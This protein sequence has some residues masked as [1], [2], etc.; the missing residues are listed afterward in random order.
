MFSLAMHG[1]LFDAQHAV[2]GYTP[3]LI[4][5]LGYPLLPWLMVPHKVNGQL[6]VSETLFNKKLRKGRCVVENAFGILKQSFKELLDKFNLHITFISDVILCYAILHNVLLRQS[7][8]KVEELQ[9]VLRIEG[10]EGE[11]VDEDGPSVD[12]GEAIHDDMTTVLGSKKRTQFGVY[13]TTRRRQ[14][15]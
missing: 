9:Q 6:L 12:A 11:I 3:Y 14:Q 4:G 1:N 10:L 15:L 7:H 5:D 2:D 8:E 13:L